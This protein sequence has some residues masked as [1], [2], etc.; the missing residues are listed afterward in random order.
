MSDAVRKRIGRWVGWLSAG[1]FAVFI[2]NVM[3]AKL[4]RMTGVAIPLLPN[5]TE[6]FL[7]HAATATFIAYALIREAQE[8]SASKAE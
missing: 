3:L 8:D 5:L 2:G 7:L 4:S 6:F 1:L